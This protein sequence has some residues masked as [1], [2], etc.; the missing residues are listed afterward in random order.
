MR[1][2]CIMLILILLAG[3]MPLANIVVAQDSG[4]DVNELQDEI[5]AREAQIDAINRKIDEYR[6][7]V[8]YYANQS[9]SLANDIALIENQQ[10]LL[11]LDLQA[12]EA[13]IQAKELE[14]VILQEAIKEQEARIS[15]QRDILEEMVF[16][17]NKKDGVGFIEVLFGA[18]DFNELFSAV[19]DLQ[20]V[21]ED[22]NT[23]LEETKQTRQ[24]LSENKLQ[25]ED[26]LDQLVVLESELEMQS[27]QLEQS[28]NAKE[29][30]IAEAE[31]SESEYRV[32][33]NEVRQEQAAISQRIVQLQQELE[34]KISSLDELGD[35]TIFT[36]PTRGIITALFH[37]PSYP[38]RHLFEHGGL[39]IAVPTGTPIQAAAPGYVAWARTGRSY[40]NYVM[41]IHANG[42][43]TLYAHLSSMNV[44]TDQFVSRGQVIGYSGST[45][46]STGPHLHFEIRADGIPTDP[47]LYL[48]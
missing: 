28:A 38:F 7:K 43:A 31:D 14:I 24:R 37:D 4:D 32:L 23:A 44:T 5:D 6:E 39:D 12:T 45:G 3:V 42:Y 40:G 46:L 16:A 18:N 25:Q 21:S 2:F 20:S 36:W 48:Q 19:E 26:S 27:V 30:L 10:A 47:L 41:I 11:E 15:Y 1:R 8:S 13:E 29:F 35:A 34:G 9:A 22:M 33:S 17:L